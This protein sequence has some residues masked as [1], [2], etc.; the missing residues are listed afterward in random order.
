LETYRRFLVLSR[1]SQIEFFSILLGSG[2]ALAAAELTG[3]SCYGVEIDPRYVD[4][5]CQRWMALTN[6]Q[7]TLDGDGRS[8]A[9]IQAERKTVPI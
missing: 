9:E 8:F 4:V 1:N 6:K 7:A 5:I 2:T 3:R